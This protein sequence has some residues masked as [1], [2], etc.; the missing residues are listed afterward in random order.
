MI[1]ILSMD[2]FLKQNKSNLPE[3][4]LKTAADK[5]ESNKNI[6]GSKSSKI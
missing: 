6:T 4:P 5:N 3:F 2:E 1:K